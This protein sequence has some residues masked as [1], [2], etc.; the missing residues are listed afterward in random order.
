MLLIVDEA[1]LLSPRLLEEIR[2]ITN[3]VRNGQLRVRVVLAGGTRLEERFASTKL[4]SF[5]QRIA[6]RCYLEPLKHDE[7][8]DYVRAHLAA[9]GAAPASIFTED[10]LTAIHRA[11]DGIPRLINQ[12]ADH[13]LVLAAAGGQPII[14]AAGINEAWSD[15]QQL[16]SVFGSEPEAVRSEGQNA[17]VEFGSLSDEED[18]TAAAAS[19]ATAIVAARRSDPSEH[20]DRI[21]RHIAEAQRDLGVVEPRRRPKAGGQFDPQAP[22]PRGRTGV[23]RSRGP[24]CRIVRGRGSDSGAD[25]PLSP[26]S[27]TPE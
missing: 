19:V 5:N 26:R 22:A 14:D 24:V 16:P 11:G 9:A 2:M 15:L 27:A 23:R 7:T 1:H 8:C 13:A 12:V 17:F 3:L 25:G 4:E 21:E 6:A 20:L 18:G 10:A